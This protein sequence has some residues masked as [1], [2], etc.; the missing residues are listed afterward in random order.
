M[1]KGTAK[2]VLKRSKTGMETEFHIIDSE[3]RISNRASELIRKIKRQNSHIQIM[4]EV[5]KSMIEFGCYP[6]IATYNPVL[7][8]VKSIE[9]A[10]RTGQEED[11]FIY[12]FAT[13]PG[14][15]NAVMRSK[16][17]YKI[18][19][20]VVGKENMT[21]S[22]RVTGFHHHYSLP[23]GVFDNEKL[24]IRLMKK[25]KLEAS[26]I[27]SYNFEIA[28][29]PALT[30]F[31]QSSPFYQGGLL[32]KDSRVIMYRGG[33][34]LRQMKGLYA[35]HQQLGGLPPYK[36]TATD[37]IDSLKKRWKRLER[38]VKRVSRVDFDTL[39]PHKLDISWN[40]VKINKHGTLEER[41]MDVNF[42]RVLSA[43]TVLLKFSL[44]EIQRAFI[45][46]IPTD[47]G[48][49]EAFKLEGNALYI[50]PHSYVRNRLQ[51]WSAYE[52]YKKKEMAF[53]AKRFFSF[54]RSVTPKKYS[55]IIMAVQEMVDERRSVSDK[56][57][58]YA[59]R[60]GYLQD[61]KISDEDAA[62]LALHYSR[63]FPHDLEGTR[64]ELERLS[65]I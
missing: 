32:G 56:I 2:R 59:K 20:K 25:S 19:E 53:Y 47:F 28:A 24:M 29:D 10:Y 39:Y 37:L 38:S 12:P 9:E 42:L 23:K 34:K 51:R 48:I 46:V 41:G 26:L 17:R 36:Q 15:F 8:M 45:N 44:K 52:G 57:I 1:G 63:E 18:H 33:K 40:P 6:D 55:K 21:N 60:K 11:L 62:S 30:L 27:S 35:R 4:P 54:A 5:G 61:N 31:T 64:R 16:K 3:G 43:V 49:D 50:P 7:D 65:A 58:R 14:R 22:P 13:Y